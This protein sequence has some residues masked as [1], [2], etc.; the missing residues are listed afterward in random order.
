VIDRIV[1]VG[2]MCSG[3]STVGPLLA[4]RLGWDF[5]DFDE[6]IERDANQSIAEIFRIHGESHF[7]DLEADL[8]ERLDGVRC[9][10][11]APG[12]GWVSQP[13]LVE[14][15]RPGS[16][17]VWLRVRP[18]TVLAR[19]RGQPDV[20]RPLLA[21]DRPLET[22]RSILAERTPLY[23]RADRVVDTDD[24][25]PAAIADRIAGMLDR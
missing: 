8:T 7:R 6:S 4:G 9:A 14:L 21:V 1:L 22:V 13:E 3:K 11:L 2:F 10:V 24:R 18:E 20:L 12:G 23:R 15:L 17:I 25:E 19:N 16:L 5:I